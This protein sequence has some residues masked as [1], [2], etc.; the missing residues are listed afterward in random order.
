LSKGAIHFLK[1]KLPVL[2]WGILIF[3]ASSIPA[4]KF[5]KFP[6]YISDKLIHAVLFCIFGLLLHLALEPQ[7]VPKNFQWKRMFLTLLVVMG[8]GAFDEFHQ[9][10]VPGRNLDVYDF[11]ADTIGGLIAISIIIFNYR[12]KKAQS[13]RIKTSA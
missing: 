11:L 6:L 8:Y 2:L 12:S 3:V 7:T 1:Y 13:N 4:S 10:F 5:P 9:H